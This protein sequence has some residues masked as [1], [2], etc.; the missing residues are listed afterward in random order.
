MMVCSGVFYFGG[1]VPILS[2]F[3]EFIG[4]SFY[5]TLRLGSGQVFD[6]FELYQQ[7]FGDVGKFGDTNMKF[8]GRLAYGE[9]FEGRRLWIELLYGCAS[10]LLALKS[11]CK[12]FLLVNNKIYFGMPASVLVLENSF[13]RI[14][15][16]IQ[17]KKLRTGKPFQL[18]TNTL[19]LGLLVEPIL[20]N[21]GDI[22]SVRV[23][24]SKPLV[25]S[26]KFAARIFLEGSLYRGVQ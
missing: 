5:D 16:I 23:S 1:K 26:C 25:L 3:N 14:I 20:I 19:Q 24:T 11:D 7:V 17:K 10:D 6:H 8:S 18:L 13:K 15:E 22:F 9:N 12:A 2:E 4:H 21:P